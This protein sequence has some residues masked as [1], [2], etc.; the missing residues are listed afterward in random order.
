MDYKNVF[1]IPHVGYL[2][3]YFVNICKMDYI[4]YSIC[5]LLYRIFIYECY[6]ILIS[7]SV[8]PI[9]IYYWEN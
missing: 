1:I 4:Y 3:R 8:F 2:Q 9:K 6:K 5:R 7:F